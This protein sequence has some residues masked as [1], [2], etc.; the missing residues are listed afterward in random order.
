M[1][2]ITSRQKQILSE[3][4]S[5]SRQHISEIARKLNLSKSTVHDHYKILRQYIKQYAT[6]VDFAKLGYSFRMN[7]IFRANSK[8]NRMISMSMQIPG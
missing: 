8:K 3:L 4:R 2:M 1:K 6:L 5:N 7:F